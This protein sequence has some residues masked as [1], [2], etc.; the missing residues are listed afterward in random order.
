M[1]PGRRRGGPVTGRRPPGRDGRA[2][3]VARRMRFSEQH[4]EVTFLFHRETG[5]REAACPAGGDSTR[6][7]HGAELRDVLDQLERL[8]GQPPGAG[9]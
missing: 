4:P 7:V 8:F 6:S 2:D 1:Q 3:Q 9:L 5:R